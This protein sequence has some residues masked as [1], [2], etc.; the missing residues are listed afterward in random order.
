MTDFVTHPSQL[1]R[2]TRLCLML[3][4]CV[5]IGVGGGYFF[6]FSLGHSGGIK[7]MVMAAVIL[8]VSAFGIV[9][10]LREIVRKQK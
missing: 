5:C 4:G 6:K 7:F 1:F 10:T 9:Q 3:L 2:I 8:A